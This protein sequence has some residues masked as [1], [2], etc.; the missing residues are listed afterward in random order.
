MVVIAWTQG[1]KVKATYVMTT[2]IDPDEGEFSVW[3]VDDDGEYGIPALLCVAF[4][5][6]DNVILWFNHNAPESL[7]LFGLRQQGDQ[8]QLFGEDQWYRYQE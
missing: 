2:E 8:L 5:K 4:D 7:N 6:H 3:N 1:G